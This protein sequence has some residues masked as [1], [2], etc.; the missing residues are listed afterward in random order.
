MIHNMRTESEKLGEE[1][2]TR[3]THEKD[4]YGDV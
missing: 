4:S 3:C 2:F 1:R